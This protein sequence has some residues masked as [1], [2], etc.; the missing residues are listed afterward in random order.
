MELLLVLME[1]ASEVRATG[2]PGSLSTPQRTTVPAS[3][4][5]DPGP[6]QSPDVRLVE[7]LRRENGEA[8]CDHRRDDASV[9]CAGSGHR[10]SGVAS[11]VLPAWL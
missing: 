6:P 2:Q 7:L 3:P 11:A 8:E 1:M 4:G 5:S 9:G 10:R